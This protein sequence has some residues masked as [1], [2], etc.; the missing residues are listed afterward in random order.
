MKRWPSREMETIVL[1]F[2]KKKKTKLDDNFFVVYSFVICFTLH[3]GQQIV[4][5]FIA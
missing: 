3:Y 5:Y 4:K 1:Y 2:V